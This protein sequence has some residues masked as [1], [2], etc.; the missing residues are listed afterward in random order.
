MVFSREIKTMSAEK[1]QICFTIENSNS[2]GAVCLLI[3][4]TALVLSTFKNGL[5]YQIYFCSKF[6]MHDKQQVVTAH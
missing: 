2:V 1:F 4:A 5:K 6:V 3:Q